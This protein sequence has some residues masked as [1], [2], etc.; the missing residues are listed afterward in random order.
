MDRHADGPF[1]S[2]HGAVPDRSATT[3][4][5]VTRYPNPQGS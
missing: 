1:T 4:W 2:S 3:T 5:R